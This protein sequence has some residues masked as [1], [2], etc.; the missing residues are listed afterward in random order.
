MDCIVCILWYAIKVSFPIDQGMEASI[1][2]LFSCL[3]IQ[4]ITKRWSALFSEKQWLATMLPTLVFV[5]LFVTCISCSTHY[6]AECRH[7]RE[8][9]YLN[10]SSGQ[11]YVMDARS[12]VECAADCAKYEHCLAIN[13]CET[14]SFYASPV[15][16]I[17]Y[18]TIPIEKC[19]DILDI[20]NCTFA[21][22][23][24][25]IVVGMFRNYVWNHFK[26]MKSSIQVH[27]YRENICG[28][29]KFSAVEG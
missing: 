22:K 7:R 16:E 23:V 15:C 28:T 21:E 25:V 18:P 3:Y 5:F 24:R 1:T 4:H 27:L 17:L 11:K 6:R 20:A 10:V 8:S 9:T 29:L 26:S 14:N 13:Y 2:K 12:F 19:D